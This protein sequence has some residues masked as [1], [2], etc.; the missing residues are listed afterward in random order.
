[1][2][3]KHILEVKLNDDDKYTIVVPDELIDELDW[4][5]DENLE[6]MIDIDDSL[7]LR[8]ANG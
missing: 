7:I 5:E 2:S 3:K 6:Y 4:N 1:M 8:S